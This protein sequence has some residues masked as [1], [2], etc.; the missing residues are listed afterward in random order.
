MRR[1]VW[2]AAV[3]ATGGVWF[4]VLLEG[5][6][7]SGSGDDSN[8]GTADGGGSDSTADLGDGAGPSD[9]GSSGT[10]G[11]TD[12]GTGGPVSNPGEVT[13]GAALSCNVDA[14]ASA[15][16]GPYCCERSDGG[17]S[18]GT[19]VAGCPA[20]AVRL[21]CDE[22]AD[23]PANRAECC[24]TATTGH[25][26]PGPDAGAFTMGNAACAKTCTPNDLRLCKTT[27]ECGDSGTCNLVTCGGGDKF[28][29]CN[30]TTDCK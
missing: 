15:G 11:G 26:G 23:C 12:S 5:C 29:A 13:C 30:T 21:E 8:I 2:L 1:F 16:P 14:G 7:S 20:N 6:G 25:A 3:A 19:N 10:E 24:L 27:S 28:Y 22:P 9:G 4:P 17:D 18:C